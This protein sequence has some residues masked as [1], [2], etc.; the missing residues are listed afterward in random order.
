M[1][2]ANTRSLKGKTEE[3]TTE[4]YDFDIVCLTETHIDSSIYSHQIFDY[5]NKNIYR[6]D[7]NLHGGGVL[8]AISDSFISKKITTDA[9]KT[10][11]E[12]LF[13]RIHES[14]L[15]GCFYR[16]PTHKDMTMLN[17]IIEDLSQRFPN[18]H[19]ILTGDMNLPGIDW[20]NITIKPQSQDRVMSKK[21]T[22]L[23]AQ[24]N[25][26]QLI[27]QPTHI[28]GNT[29]DLICT[30]QPEMIQSHEVIYPGLSDHFIIKAEIKTALPVKQFPTKVI[31]LYS[32][33][34]LDSFELVM[35]DTKHRLKEMDDVNKMWTFFSRTL[36]HAI[37]DF[38][39]KK[40]VADRP[41]TEPVWFTKESRKLVT[42]QRQLYNRFRRSGD[43]FDQKQYTKARK[44]TK[45]AIRKIKRDYV[46]NRICKPLS[47]GNCKPFY[48]HL[49]GIKNTKNQIML[50]D[51]S[52]FQTDDPCKCAIM[53]NTYF[54]SQ[55]NKNHSLAE[56]CTVNAFTPP[57]IDICGIIK[58]VKDLKGGKAPGRDGIRKEDLMIDI[59]QTSDCL[60]TIFNKSLELGILPEEWKIANVTPI[61]K[62]GTTETVSN[63][64]PI[65]LTSIPCK[66]LEHIVLRNL[67][68][69]VDKILHNRQHGFRQGLSCETQLC[70][71]LNDILTSVD[72]QKSVHAAVLDFAKAFD[73]VPH[74][75]L[76]EKLS[77]T[78]ID[79]YI[80]SWIHNFL[81][82]RSQCVVLDGKESNFL[83]VTSGVPQGS[84][85]GPVL[86]L[87]F[88]NDLP[89]CVTCSVSLFADDTL[90]Y[91]EISTTGDIDSFQQ[92]LDALGR[93]A[94][95]WGMEFNVNKSKILIFNNTNNEPT[96]T[97][98]LNKIALEQVSNSRYLGVTLQDDL[99]FNKHI[100][101]KI[102]AAKKQ[103]G[104]VKRALFRA[105][106]KAKLLAYKSLCLPHLEY[107]AAAW[108]PSNKGEIKD[109]ELV[110]NQAIRFIAN[111]KGTRGISEAMDKLGV[112]PLQQRRQQQRMR[113]LMRVLSKEDIHPALTESYDKLIT[114][115][116]NFIQTRSQRHGVPITLQTN[117]S[118]FHNSFLP[119][120]IRDL[121]L[122]T[123]M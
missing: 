102:T 86:F 48:R 20:L 85:L 62:S 80:I 79:D 108:D 15:V 78:D 13:V 54:H 53:L 24:H 96:P 27:T 11:D 19:I 66:I 87:L 45:A 35:N 113:L 21:F 39:P 25:L 8:I 84:V 58:L 14:I 117:R 105:P 56:N 88:I 94:T 16:P 34:D 67:L 57:K 64:R 118:L 28:H 31:K 37:N 10:K 6:K 5:N 44:D 90:L 18:D 101:T 32:K 40:T 121:K 97:Y 17:D 51:E 3:L 46:T 59:E 107:A 91:Q 106:Q 112:I 12:I 33:V 43:P 81:L 22:D 55:F 95:K 47:E 103:L 72:Q 111:L 77:K 9:D 89:E 123:S 109:L 29:L 60:A 26:H 82:H 73:R 65:S 104:M 63:Y 116:T 36:K 52:N 38:V 7:R 30:N 69:K 42:K 122:Q 99:R 119:K 74:A 76:M 61:H 92:N 1:F 70:A 71:T 114:I 49:K 23:L 110:Q 83:P 4:T 68:A 98:T 115:P 100:E 50:R 120:T 2:T 93:W 75:L 41:K